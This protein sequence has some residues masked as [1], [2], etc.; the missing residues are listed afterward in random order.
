MAVLNLPAAEYT[1][2]FND[3]ATT[4]ITVDPGESLEE[5]L[6]DYLEA[7]DVDR[8]A[9]ASVELARSLGRERRV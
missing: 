1:I 5:I 9:V 8:D 3:G 7:R 6:A 2:A 4:T